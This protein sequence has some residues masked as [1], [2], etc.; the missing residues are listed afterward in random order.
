MWKQ[1]YS[2][3][4]HKAMLKSSMSSTKWNKVFC[5]DFLLSLT[6]VKHGICCRWTPSW[7]SVLMVMFAPHSRCEV[8]GCWCWG[9][10]WWRVWCPVR[11]EAMGGASLERTTRLSIKCSV[12]T[13]SGYKWSNNT[14]QQ[15]IFYFSFINYNTYSR[16]YKIFMYVFIYRGSYSVSDR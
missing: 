14:R 15:Y 12:A 4:N 8:A 16:L 9:C 2:R 6:F 7:L 10:W 13:P 11:G 5:A 3:T 1:I